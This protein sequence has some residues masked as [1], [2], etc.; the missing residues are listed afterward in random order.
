MHRFFLPPNQCA[1]P[2]LF[3]GGREAHHAMHVLRLRGGEE[4][5]LLDGVGNEYVC[6]ITGHDR[7]KLQLKVLDKHETP[8]LPC[9][10]TLVQALPK[11]KII[12]AIIQKATELGVSRIV[13]LL[14]ERVVVDLDAKH[15]IQK[16]GKWQAIAVEAIKQCG[17]PWLPIVETP[18][19]TN[20]FLERKETSELNLIGSLQNNSRHPAGFLGAFKAEHGRMP[21]S[22]S[23]W[24]GP[25]GDFTLGEVRAIEASGARPINLGPRVLRVE[26]AAIYCLSFLDYEL[27]RS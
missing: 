22:I 14:S 5:S 2:V 9:K 27:R 24:V 19:T 21:T 10:I 23:V 18:I 16:A 15:A 12:E 26:T 25:E 8:P 1:G 7:D 4:V 20:A 17:T 3:L 11:G 13:P 6:Q